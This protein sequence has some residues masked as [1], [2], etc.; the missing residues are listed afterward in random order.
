M[1]EK[2]NGS[3]EKEQSIP[4]IE[5]EIL[6]H[7]DDE[8]KESALGFIAYL[9]ANQLTPRQWFGP[10]YWFIPWENMNLCGIHL[11]GFNSGKDSNGWVFWFFSDGYGG[12]AGEELIKLVHD[13]VGQCGDCGGECTKGVDMT[14]FGKEYANV[15][16]QFPVRIEDPDSSTLERIKALIEH[17]KKA[18]PTSKGM[19]VH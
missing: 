8:L 18:A 3:L 6:T 10:G 15:C 5:D 11:Y 17:W 16:I 13:H 4:R 9:N 2:N 12:E 14:I 19:H 1:A 7:L